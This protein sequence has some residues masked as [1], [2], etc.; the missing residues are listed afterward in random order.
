M[1]TNWGYV[2]TT[3]WK[4]VDYHDRTI[5]E[6]HELD[7]AVLHKHLGFVCLE[8]IGKN[9]CDVP[10]FKSYMNQSSSA[11]SSNENSLLPDPISGNCPVITCE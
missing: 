5:M 4:Y 11:H 9:L 1:T 7:Q 8:Q 3:N 10:V 2:V 6:Y